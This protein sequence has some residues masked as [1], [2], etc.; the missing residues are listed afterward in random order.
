MKPR[1]S[2][3]DHLNWLARAGIQ[4]FTSK[5]ILDVGCGSG[6][7][8]HKAMSDG[9]T[10][11]VGIDVIE[12]EFANR[13]EQYPWSFLQIDLNQSDWS[14]KVAD[15]FDLIFAFDIIEHLDSPYQFLRSC[16]KLLSNTGI[17]VV[18]TPNL[19]SWER[20]FRPNSWSGVTDNQHKVL[21]TRY[22]LNFLLNRCGFTKNKLIA[23]MRALSFLGPLQPQIGGQ[24]LII[25]QK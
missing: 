9:A 7:I 22:S 16:E 5:K 20:F 21:F 18:T 8:C 25:A 6:F 12:P 23:P 15:I 19:L 14:K 13:L 17:L 10:L 3:I 4:N 2:D 11:A 24:M 1:P